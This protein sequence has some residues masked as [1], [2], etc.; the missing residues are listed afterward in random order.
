[1]IISRTPL[2]IGL[3]G[4]GSDLP[5]YYKQPGKFGMVINAAIDKY[6]YV[7]VKKRHDDYIYLKYSQNEVVHKSR[8]DDI[9]HDF[10]KETLKYLNINEGLEIIN[11]ADIPT[12]GTGLGSSSSF[13]VGLLNCLH[14]LK[15]ELVSQK[16]LADEACEIEINLCKKP[17]GKQDQYIAAFGGLR[18]THFRMIEEKEKITSIPIYT[19]QKCL[20]EISEYIMMFY[21]GHTRES[22]DILDEQ[23]KKTVSHDIN[24]FMDKNVQLTQNLLIEFLQRYSL[25]NNFDFLGNAVRENWELKK[26][27][28]SNVTNHDINEMISATISGGAIGSKI[29]GA[30]GGGFIVSIVNPTQKFIFREIMKKSKMIQMPARIDYFGTRILLNIEDG[31]IWKS[32]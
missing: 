5:S 17:I 21:T 4:G 24:Q 6:V 16:Q 19:E 14:S 23:N 29:T 10:I 28:S 22:K 1:M 9:K 12:K 32:I 20:D 13:L 18:V 8:I 25:Y 15:N 7:L 30:G 27:F 3:C 2:R 11:W 31:I 26:N